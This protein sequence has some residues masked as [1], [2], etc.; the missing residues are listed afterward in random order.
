MTAILD[1]KV[2]RKEGNSNSG[3]ALP[4]NIAGMC[5][6]TRGVLAAFLGTEHTRILLST[7]F[8]LQSLAGASSYFITPSQALS[9]ATGVLDMQVALGTSVKTDYNAIG[10]E[11]GQH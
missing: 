3:Q 5:L 1:A 7:C 11:M 10:Q 6:P 4:R 2:I 8:L 9:Q